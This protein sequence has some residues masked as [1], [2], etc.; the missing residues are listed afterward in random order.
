[1]P[2]MGMRELLE[3]MDQNGVRWAGGAGAMGG[4]ARNNEAAAAMG[5]RYIRPAGGPQWFSLERQGGSSALENADSPAFQGR[6]SGIE[7]ELRDAGARVIGEI[8]VNN[9]QS[10]P[11]SFSKTRADAPTVRALLDLAGKY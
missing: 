2:W 4:P 9:L 7:A 11:I 10:A 8:I 3:H 6:L 1:M 5:K